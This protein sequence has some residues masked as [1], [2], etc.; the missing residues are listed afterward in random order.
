MNMAVCDIDGSF[1]NDMKFPIIEGEK[2]YIRTIMNL[3]N[4]QIS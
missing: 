3:K 4:D 1:T 2:N